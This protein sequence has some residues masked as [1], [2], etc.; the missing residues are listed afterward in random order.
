MTT[1]KILL[2]VGGV[3]SLFVLV[4]AL[5]VG[6]VVWVAYSAI[7]KSEAAQT[8]KTFLRS[9]ETLKSDIGEVRDFG[10]WMTGGINA[11]DADG[12]ATLTLK[13]IG[14]KK[15]VPARVNLTYRNGRS[16]VVVGASYKNE[17]GQDVSLLNPYE[18]GAEESDGTGI[19]NTERD[20]SGAQPVAG[21]DEADFT[22]NVLQA[23][24][25]VLVVLVSKYSLD[26]RALEQ[27]LDKLS[28]TYAERI[29]LVRYHVDEQPA[30]LRRFHVTQLP[31]LL[32]FKDGA[33]R[34][35]V[36]RKLTEQ[37][38]VRMLDKYSGAE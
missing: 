10:F 32:L 20:T 25:P 38:L 12:E 33:E 15:T 26:S 24:K 31:V 28:E 4:V 36:T 35:R 9:N 11:H 18:Q 8:A 1:K 2:I 7:G 17:S 23:E 14:A 37:E 16:W 30:T 3:F 19:G 21:F 34:E 27:S 13:V 5:I 6:A 29:G 22:S